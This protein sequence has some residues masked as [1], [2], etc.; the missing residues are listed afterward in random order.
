VPLWTQNNTFLLRTFFSLTR[1]LFSLPLL[2]QAVPH[3]WRVLHCFVSQR[4]V[5]AAAP[6]LVLLNLRILIQRPKQRERSLCSN[7][8][9]GKDSAGLSEVFFF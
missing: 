5:A 2:I 9:C 1:F 6:L 3:W 8:P 4:A 7:A